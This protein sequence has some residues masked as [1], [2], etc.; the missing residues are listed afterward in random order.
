MENK[1]NSGP[2]AERTT[3]SS[4]ERQVPGASA[5]RGRGRKRKR[6]VRGGQQRAG[7][8]RPAR[9]PDVSQNA[10]QMPDLGLGS[11]SQSSQEVDISKDP[12]TWKKRRVRVLRALHDGEK[13]SM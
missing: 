1:K 5:K 7:A 8:G 2:S 11:H 3:P 9:P 6:G 4:V 13:P 12:T 10:P